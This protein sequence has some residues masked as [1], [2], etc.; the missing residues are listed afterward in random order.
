M[1]SEAFATANRALRAKRRAFSKEI[2]ES[3]KDARSEV[4]WSK[5][6]FIEKKVYFEQCWDEIVTSTSDCI[7]LVNDE[8]EQGEIIEELKEHIEGLQAGVDILPKS[9]YYCPQ[10]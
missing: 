10:A 3:L 4:W 2:T 1:V 7:N 8:E 5:E 9:G 6:A